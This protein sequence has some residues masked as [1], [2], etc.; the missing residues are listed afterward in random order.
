MYRCLYFPYPILYKHKRLNRVI[1]PPQRVNTV[2][3]WGYEFIDQWRAESMGPNP[4]VEVRCFGNP[5]QRVYINN[6]FRYIEE[7]APEDIA[8]RYRFLPCVRELLKES[9]DPPTAGRR[10]NLL[11]EGQA[12]P[13][14]EKFIVII[15]N[16][17]K[18]GPG[19][20]GYRLVNFYPRT[21][22]A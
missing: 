15:E 16:N 13:F 8:R 2:I 22:K 7:K 10:G 18:I 20:Y 12:P 3:S 6:A 17:A 14:K 5:S 1:I 11:L 9:S 19:L 4:Y 21:D